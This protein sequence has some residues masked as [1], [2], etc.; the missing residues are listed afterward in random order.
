MQMSTPSD[1]FWRQAFDST[2]DVHS[3]SLFST[4]G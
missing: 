3:R 2:F 4:R 1:E